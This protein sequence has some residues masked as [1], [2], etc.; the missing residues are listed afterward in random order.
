MV[1]GAIAL[2][3][4]KPVSGRNRQIGDY[5]CAVQLNQLPQCDPSDGVESAA[6][7]GVEETFRF[8]VCKGL[9]HEARARER[10]SVIDALQTVK[11]AVVVTTET[12]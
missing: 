5:S 4:F 11:A 1:A 2:K 10:L 7:F 9:D 8:R 3:G 12:R 6:L